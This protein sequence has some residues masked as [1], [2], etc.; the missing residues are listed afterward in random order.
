MQCNTRCIMCISFVFPTW[1]R[2][3]R[4]CRYP[5]LNKYAYNY[6]YELRTLGTVWSYIPTTNDFTRCVHAQREWGNRDAIEKPT[7][8]RAER[9]KFCKRRILYRKVIGIHAK[10]DIC[11]CRNSQTGCGTHTFEYSCERLFVQL[12]LCGGI[13][14]NSGGWSDLHVSLADVAL[15]VA[16]GCR[17]EMLPSRGW[18]LRGIIK[19]EVER[20]RFFGLLFTFTTSFAF[21]F[22]IFY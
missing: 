22:Y 6:Q 15:S 2:H 3:H 5:W 19:Q 1:S 20:C 16:L 14:N 10:G 17:S 9:N 12:T 21:I 8:K 7:P 11:V 4:R 13:G 18:S